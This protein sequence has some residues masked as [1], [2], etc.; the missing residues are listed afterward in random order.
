MDGNGIELAQLLPPALTFLGGIAA[1]LITGWFTR[2]NTQDTT[3][4]ATEK[5][6]TEADQTERRDTIADRDGLIKTLVDRLGEVETRMGA[7]EDEVREVRTH[8]NALINFI[9]RCIAVLQHH[10]LEEE[11]PK[12]LPKGVEL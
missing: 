10:G 8:N 7:V 5:A 1:V 11:I 6:A 12:P 2:R 9:F 3:E 4:A